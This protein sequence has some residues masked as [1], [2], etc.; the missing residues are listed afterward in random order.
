M[1]DL[2]RYS[3]CTLSDDGSCLASHYTSDSYDKCDEALDKYQDMYPNALVD[4]YSRADLQGL[5]VHRND[6][7]FLY[8]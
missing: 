1:A 2:K 6:F 7:D 5:V 4:I 3:I 8:L